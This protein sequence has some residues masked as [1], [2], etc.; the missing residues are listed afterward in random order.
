MLW[1]GLGGVFSGSK[2]SPTFFTVASDPTQL[3]QKVTDILF[4]FIT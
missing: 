3:P 4:C 2:I 1:S